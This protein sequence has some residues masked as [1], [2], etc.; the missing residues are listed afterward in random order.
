MLVKEYYK[1]DTRVKDAKEVKEW[2]QKLRTQICINV[3]KNLDLSQGDYEGIDL[4]YCDLR[5][6]DFW[7][8]VI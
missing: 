7:E 2:F 8:K 4:R 6:S 3:F 5:G 1:E